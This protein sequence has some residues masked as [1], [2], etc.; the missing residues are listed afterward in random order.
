MYAKVIVDIAN[1][2]VDRLFTYAVPDDMDIACGQRVAV[3]FGAGNRE[4]EGFVL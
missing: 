1:V 2:A 4:K 3:P